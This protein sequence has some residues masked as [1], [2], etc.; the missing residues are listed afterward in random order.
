MKRMIHDIWYI[1]RREFLAVTGDSAVL[2]FFVALTLA[3]PVVYTLIY[4]NETVHEVPVAVV[5]HSQSAASRE[6]VR[7]WDAT[8]GVE[9]VVRCTDMEEARKALWQ[10]EVYGIL[11]IPEGFAGQLVRNEQAYVSLYCDMGGLLNYKSLL[12]T[13]SDVAVLMGKEIQVEGLPYASVKQ[14][15]LTASPVQMTEVRMFNPQSGYASFIIPAI[16]ILVIQQ[17][18]LLGVGTLAGT[19]RERSKRRLIIPVNAHYR[20]PVRIVLGRAFAYLPIYI[21]VSVWI[22]IVV[23]GIFNLT[24]IGIKWD[25]FLFLIPFLLG[26]VFLAQ[27]LS[28]LCREREMPFLIFVF[29]SVPLMFMSGLSWPLQAIPRYWVAVSE[30]FP[31]TFGIRGFVKLSNMG[32]TLSDVKP[33][34]CSLW[35]L[36]AVYFFVACLLYYRE[37]RKA[38]SNKSLSI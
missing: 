34:F 2:T 11:E 15:E 20:N 17:S 26:C 1:F 7:R 16:L 8:S 31:S 9:V 23:P 14:Q 21:I 30:V 32:A 22:F 37:T 25:M 3:Y 36:A 28:F 4:S 13:A 24:R 12:Q 38:N 33:E 19:A 35:I 10:K 18:L 27:A 29:T 5:D 6:F